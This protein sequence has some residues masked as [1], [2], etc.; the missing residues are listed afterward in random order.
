MLSFTRTRRWRTNIAASIIVGA[1]IVLCGPVY[2]ALNPNAGYLVS[3]AAQ[4]P[5]IPAVIIQATSMSSMSA[6]ERQASRSLAKYRACN[7]VLLTA[8][9]AIPLGIAAYL[10]APLVGEQQ[11]G[12]YDLGPVTVIRNLIALIGA[13]FIGASVIGSSLGWII[14]SAWAI[15]P[16]VLLTATSTSNSFITLVV[17]P[18]DSFT[19]FMVALGIWFG[20]LL[21]ASGGRRGTFSVEG[22]GRRALLRSSHHASKRRQVRDHSPRRSGRATG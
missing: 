15:L 16:Y 8:A 11:T 18:D 22:I 4:L 6:Q 2:Y 21:A 12:G 14:P 1:L 10:Y 17:Q 9:A 7:Y 13:G 3:I 20:G 5:L 19:A